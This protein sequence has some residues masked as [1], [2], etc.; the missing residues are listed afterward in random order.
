MT[1]KKRKGDAA[2]QV[3]VNRMNPGRQR[4]NNRYEIEV[5]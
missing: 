2:I 3:E 4:E 1:G 5:R